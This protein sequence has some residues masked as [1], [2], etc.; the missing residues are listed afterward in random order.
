MTWVTAL[1][2]DG[3]VTAWYLNAEQEARWRAGCCPLFHVDGP[4]ELSV[5]PDG[6]RWCAR[7]EIAFKEDHGRSL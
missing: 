4:Q 5:R 1:F 7:G 3:K 2:P 6:W